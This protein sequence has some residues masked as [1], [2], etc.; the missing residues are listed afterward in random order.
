MLSSVQLLNGSIAITV[1]T[2]REHPKRPS[3]LF[4]CHCIIGGTMCAMCINN[5]AQGG[6]SCKKTRIPSGILFVEV[7]KKRF[8]LQ[9]VFFNW[10]YPEFAKCRPVSNRFQ[11]NDRVPDWPPP[12]IGKR[13]SVW[14]SEC[15][16]NT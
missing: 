11:K 1:S 10:A 6:G 8:F 3:L 16:S 12:L 14:R 7:P 15:D 9:G 5:L 2:D 13:L 4:I